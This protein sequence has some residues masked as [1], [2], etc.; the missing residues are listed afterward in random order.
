MEQ[1]IIPAV[2]A[3]IGSIIAYLLNKKDAT[4]EN[5]LNELKKQIALL[6]VKHDAD[7]AA[8]HEL[9]IQIAEMHYKKPEVDFKILKIEETI[10]KSMDRLGEKF[11]KLSAALLDHIQKEDA[12]K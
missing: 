5:E 9:R 1:Y 2:L 8:L 12:R 7:V 6:F 11:D 4:Q 3:G 10:E